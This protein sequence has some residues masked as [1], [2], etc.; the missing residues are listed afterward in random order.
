MKDKQ[1][2]S[3]KEHEV[4]KAYTYSKGNRKYTLLYDEIYNLFAERE[5]PITKEEQNLLDILRLMP[6]NSTF[7]M[8]TSDNEF[9]TRIPWVFS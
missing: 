3:R 1:M 6:V 2:K 4:K 7:Y 9:Y 8:H 5:K